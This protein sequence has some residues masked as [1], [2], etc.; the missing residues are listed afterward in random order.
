MQGR[1]VL[2][3]TANKIAENLYKK[4]VKC[5]QVLHASLHKLSVNRDN[6]WDERSV[7]KDCSGNKRLFVV[8]QTLDQILS[9]QRMIR[10][11]VKDPY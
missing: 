9:K 3:L 7:T 10:N 4:T 1:D 8:K 6:F 11:V 2:H 5:L